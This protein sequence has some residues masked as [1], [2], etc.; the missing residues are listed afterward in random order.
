MNALPRGMRIS[1]ARSVVFTLLIDGSD[2]MEKIALQIQNKVH[3]ILVDT[4][5]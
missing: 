1:P 2:S 5:R 3:E 4:E